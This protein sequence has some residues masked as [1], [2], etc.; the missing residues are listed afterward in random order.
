MQ[1][2]ALKSNDSVELISRYRLDRFRR[3]STIVT[4]AAIIYA[5]FVIQLI[6]I[7]ESFRYFL[8]FFAVSAAVINFLIY[9][10]MP[11]SFF[12]PNILLFLSVL[13]T[14]IVGFVAQITGGL[15]SPFAFFYT[16]ILLSAIVTMSFWRAGIVFG[17][18]LELLLAHYL[19]VASPVSYPQGSFTHLIITVSQIAILGVY[20]FILVRDLYAEE[21]LSLTQSSD[22]R[23]QLF[24]DELITHLDRSV[25]ARQPLSKTLNDTLATTATHLKAQS[26]LVILKDQLVNSWRAASTLNIAS[27]Y[28]SKINPEVVEV[29]IMSLLERTKRTFV[30]PS[31]ARIRHLL[32]ELKPLNLSSLLLSPLLVEGILVGAIVLGTSKGGFGAAERNFLE[33]LS[34]DVSADIANAQKLEAEEKLFDENERIA[35]EAEARLEEMHRLSHT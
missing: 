32:P 6:P 16:I 24:E 7:F 26:G 5:I 31:K 14:F 34:K 13:N 9:R 11:S 12:R 19:T 25:V 4:I 29:G 15:A 17:L 23:E 30:I 22:L 28:S 20:S 10:F 35:R 27:E 3:L 21:N 18:V 1:P 8:Q 2:S 33:R